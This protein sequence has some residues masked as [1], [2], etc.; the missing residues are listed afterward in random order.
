MH[1][2]RLPPRTPAQVADNLAYELVRCFA[3]VT[4]LLDD[5][6][7]GPGRPP[8]AVADELIRRVQRRVH[9]MV[10]V[11]G[12]DEIGCCV[13]LLAEAVDNLGQGLRLR[14]D[15]GPAFRR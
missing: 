13:S 3:A 14:P 1:D 4:A 10:V 8:D 9:D 15:A 11:F 7:A 12:A 5:E 6:V 2:E